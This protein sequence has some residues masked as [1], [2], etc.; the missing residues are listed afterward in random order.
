[1]DEKEKL[2]EKVKDR[3]DDA[4]AKAVRDLFRNMTDKEQKEAVKSCKSEILLAEINRRNKL[5]SKQIANV[6]K[7]LR[8]G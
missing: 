3:M 4:Q 8:G 6:K 7:A 1:M 2:R 5:Q